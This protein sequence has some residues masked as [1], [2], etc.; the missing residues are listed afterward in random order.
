MSRVAQW[1]LLGFEDHIA[2]EIGDRH[3]GRR[4]E[5]ERRFGRGLEE[6]LFKLRQLSGTDQRL[7]LDEERHVRFH[8]TVL[9]RV[10]V[11]HE[12]DQCTLHPGQ[13]PAHYHESRAG[14]L[15][16]TLE[17]EH[18]ESLAQFDVFPGRKAEFGLVAPAPDLGVISFLVAVRHVVLNQIGQTQLEVL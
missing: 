7:V 9:L 8:V 15:A 12:L 5:I 17:I 2:S 10:H 13:L 4:D 16:G 6:I 1:Q 14:H 18:L 11:E 3:L